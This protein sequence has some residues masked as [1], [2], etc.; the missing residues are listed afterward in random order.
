MKLDTKYRQL[1][2]AECWKITCVHAESGLKEYNEQNTTGSAIAAAE[3][4]VVKAARKR[5]VDVLDESAL[6]GASDEQRKWG[7][8]GVWIL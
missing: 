5:F 7:S 8:T 1:A 4:T 2:L 3:A 6:P